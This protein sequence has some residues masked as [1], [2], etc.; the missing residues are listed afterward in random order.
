MFRVI[1]VADEAR[2]IIGICD[3]QKLFRWLGDALSLVVNKIDTENYK[4][5]IDICSQGCSCSEGSTCNNPAGC[6]RRCI[7]LP[8]EVET[9]IAVNIGVQPVL[10]RDQLFSFHLN[11]PGDCRTTCEWAWSDKGGFHCTYKDLIHPAKL[12]AS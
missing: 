3:D 12:V 10:G 7:A 5:F 2:K 9:V 4:G 11:G 1:D 8:R 6:G